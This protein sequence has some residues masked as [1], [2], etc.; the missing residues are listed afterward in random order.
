VCEYSE[1][2][3]GGISFPPASSF[4]ERA[5]ALRTR[6]VAFAS[7]SLGMHCQMPKALVRVTGNFI[8]FVPCIV[9]IRKQNASDCSLYMYIT[10]S[11]LAFMHVLIRK[12]PS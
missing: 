5:F 8:L 10:I 2:S 4:A 1:L 7:A 11:H 6:K 3:C 9:D 12:G